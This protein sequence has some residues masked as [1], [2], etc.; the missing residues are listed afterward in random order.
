MMVWRFENNIVFSDFQA[1]IVNR[2]LYSI[3]TVSFLADFPI[4]L[5][6]EFMFNIKKIYFL[7]ALDDSEIRQ[8]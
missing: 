7:L 8:M 4:M 5:A 2:F 1:G 6:V 3:Q